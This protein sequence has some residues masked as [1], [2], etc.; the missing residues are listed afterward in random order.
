MT[1]GKAIK[2]LFF[3]PTLLAGA[4]LLAACYPSGEVEE[5]Q[6]IAEVVEATLQ[7]MTPSPPPPTPTATE[8]TPTATEMSHTAYDFVANMCQAEWTNNGEG[9]AC[10]GEN[11]H[12]IGSGYVG[13]VETPQMEGR[14]TLPGPGLLTHPSAKDPFYGIFGAYPAFTVQANDQFRA[15]VGC[16]EGIEVDSCDVQFSL[17]YYDETGGYHNYQETGLSWD[18]V[19]DGT[20]TNVSADLSFLAGKTVRLVLVVRDNGSSVGD[21]ATW[22]QPQIWRP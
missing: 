7:A 11:A 15:T 4:L 2:K 8:V 16:L 19:D 13:V 21:Y 22:V 5:T 12:I 20:T 3:L 1:I 9:L 6:D 17:E 14:M 18:E 10:P